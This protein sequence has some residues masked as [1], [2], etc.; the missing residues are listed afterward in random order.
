MGNRYVFGFV[1]GA[2]A[3]AMVSAAPTS[4]ATGCGKN[5]DA[6]FNRASSAYASGNYALTS[7]NMQEAASD[8][9]ACAKHARA[10]R[11]RDRYTYFYGESLYVAG[12]AEAKMHHTAKVEEFWGAGAMALK[13][14]RNSNFLTDDQRVLTVHALTVM[15]ATLK[16]L[17]S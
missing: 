13:S 17:H 3:A 12:E 10:A 2:L 8:Y 16:A 5:V 6:L 9:A 7:A 11:A 14:V 1:A 4:A 15:E